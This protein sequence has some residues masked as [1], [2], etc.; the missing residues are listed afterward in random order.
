[1]LADVLPSEV[2]LGTPARCNA[3]HR[4]Q[5]GQAFHAQ[6]VLRRIS[7][8]RTHA[9]SFRRRALALPLCMLVDGTM[10]TVYAGRGLELLALRVL[11]VQDSLHATLHVP[12]ASVRHQVLFFQPMIKL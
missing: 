9:H 4:A 6:L 1:M 10:P 7:V 2:A 11:L 5:Q 8:T 12:L 3:R